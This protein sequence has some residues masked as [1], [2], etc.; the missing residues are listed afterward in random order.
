MDVRWVLALLAASLP[1]VAQ[2]SGPTV[3]TAARNRFET[4]LAA[5]AAHQAAPVIGSRSTQTQSFTLLY[6][7]VG[8]VD[9]GMP[10]GLIRDRAGNLYGTTFAGGEFGLGV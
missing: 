9:G 2:L 7:L 3:D 1:S 8:G 5:A 6:S 10:A 4:G